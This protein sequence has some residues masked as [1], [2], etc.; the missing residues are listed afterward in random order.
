ML[1]SQTMNGVLL[2][3]ILVTMLKVINY[4]RL[5]G[6][7]VNGR[8]YN[9]VCWITAVILIAWAAIL[10]VATFFPNWMVF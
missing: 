1:V 5:M 8:I 10:I 4:R 6:K 3:V 2:P 7:F 9:I